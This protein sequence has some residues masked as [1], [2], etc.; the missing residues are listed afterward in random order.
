MADFLALLYVMFPCFIDT[1]SYG[2][3][4]QVWYSIVSIPDL[5]LLHYS[6][7]EG[8]DQESIQSCTISDLE[9]HMEKSKTQENTIHKRFKRSAF[10]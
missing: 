10:S 9:H 7:E 6:R 8:K 5:W 3:S 4:G 2:A 1:F